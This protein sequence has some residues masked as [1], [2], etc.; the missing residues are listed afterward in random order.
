MPTMGREVD[1][2]WAMDVL[3]HDGPGDQAT[4]PAGGGINRTAGP[5]MSGTEGRLIRSFSYPAI[6]ATSVFLC[7]PDQKRPVRT[8]NSFYIRDKETFQLKVH[9]AVHP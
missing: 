7:S 1:G 2:V 3:E 6:V 8:L 4:P 5:S 9:I